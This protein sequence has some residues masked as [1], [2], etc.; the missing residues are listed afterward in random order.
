MSALT[1]T[2][3]I[4]TIGMTVLFI[5]LVLITATFRQALSRVADAHD[6][7]MHNDAQLVRN[8]L[9]RLAAIRWED[10]VTMQTLQEEPEEGGFLTPE[11]QKS[12]AQT[13]VRVQE[14]DRWGPLSRKEQ[15]TQLSD[16]EQALLDEDFPEAK[17]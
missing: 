1:A 17:P 4:A 14:P 2:V 10:Y 12:E 5:A 7:Q 6:A 9:D 13:E 15:K 16:T 3:V 8:L 11:E